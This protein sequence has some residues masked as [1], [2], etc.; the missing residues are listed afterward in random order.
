MDFKR[1]F[2]DIPLGFDISSENRLKSTILES[3]R[4]LK[5]REI[6]TPLGLEYL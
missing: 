5:N 2:E 3:G 4:P 6:S 1:F